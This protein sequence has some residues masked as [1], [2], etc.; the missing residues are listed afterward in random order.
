MQ[1]LTESQKL[2]AAPHQ[3]YVQQLSEPPLLVALFARRGYPLIVARGRPK[4][5][6][7]RKDD[8]ESLA[9]PDASGKCQQQGRKEHHHMAKAHP[10]A[11]STPPLA[12][13]VLPSLQ[14]PPRTPSAPH[15]HCACVHRRWR[16]A[17]VPGPRDGRQHLARDRATAGDPCL[18]RPWRARLL[19]VRAHSNKVFRFERCLG[20]C[21]GRCFGCRCLRC[22]CLGRHDKGGRGEGSACAGTGPSEDGVRDHE[23]HVVGGETIKLEIQVCMD[24]K[25]PWG[26][27]ALAKRHSDHLPGLSCVPAVARRAL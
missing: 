4:G 12:S 24:K 17:C 8:G 22:R 18:H 6:Y 21:L 27:C 7:L 16:C 26:R 23:R 13:P 15:S 11:L 10:T 1:G 14:S 3:I 25:V 20:R 2:E 9:A 19:P 5:G